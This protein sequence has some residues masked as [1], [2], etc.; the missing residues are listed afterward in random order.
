MTLADVLRAAEAAPDAARKNVLFIA[1]DDL[2]RFWAATAQ[3][4]SNR[5]T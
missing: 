3:K 5:R 4:T 1:V 2:S